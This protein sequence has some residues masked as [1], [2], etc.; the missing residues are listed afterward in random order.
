M[1]P[2]T[3]K[4]GKQHSDDL[5][6]N[7]KVKNVRGGGGEG[8]I[9]GHWCCST[10]GTSSRGSLSLHTR[11]LLA[12]LAGWGDDSG[13]GCGCHQQQAQ[14]R[15]TETGHPQASLC[16]YTQ[17]TGGP[18]HNACTTNDLLTQLAGSGPAAKGG[19]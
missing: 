14:A 11:L 19:G 16:G 13:L 17:G 2:V 5:S 18:Q 9:P 10:R 4:A 8:P 3:T 6:N 1:V 12:P 7:P 15:S